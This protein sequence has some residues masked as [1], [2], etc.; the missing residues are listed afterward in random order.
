MTDIIV[1]GAGVAGMTAALYALRNGKSV[2]VLEKNNIGGQ[3]AESPRVENFPTIKSISGTELAD[4]LFD[5][6]TE[7]GAV[8]KFGDVKRVEKV[9]EVFKVETEFETLE[10]RAVILAT[11][12]VHRKLGL[13]GEDRLIGH[14]ISYCALCDGAFYEGK[15]VVLIGDANTAL[16]YALLLSSYCKSVKLITLFD[17][18]FG[19]KELESAV[20]KKPNIFITHSSRLIELKGGDELSALVFEKSDGSRF[21]VETQALFV[22]IGQVP[23]NEAFS[24]L[25]ELDGG[26]FVADENMCTKTP[27]LFVAGDCRVKKVRQ[28]TTASSDGAIAAT[29]AST[30]LETNA[31]K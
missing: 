19:D 18:F 17:R 5:Q 14:G 27:G 11:G 31:S 21:T 16:Q 10:S 12:V 30:Y 2:T 6:I 22:A 3:I 24:E 13:E 23:N 25:A 7:K 4:R 20:L 1:V 26:Y 9:G 28:L 8:F 29:S 15:D